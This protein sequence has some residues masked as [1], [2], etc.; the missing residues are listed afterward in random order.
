MFLVSRV[1]R[2]LVLVLMN[3][4]TRRL[5]T[6]LT[7]LLTTSVACDAGNNSIHVWT[8]STVVP[9]RTQVLTRA[10]NAC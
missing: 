7:T 2:A 4:L 5:T 3:F 8:R 1:V 10:S 9:H 6:L